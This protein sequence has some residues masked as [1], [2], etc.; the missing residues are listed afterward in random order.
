M[1]GCRALA[2]ESPS[3]LHYHTATAQAAID[4]TQPTIRRG[5]ATRTV[6]KII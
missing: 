5:G 4:L 6:Q 1:I 2:A 3:A